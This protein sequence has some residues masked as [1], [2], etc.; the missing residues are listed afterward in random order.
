M[1]EGCIIPIKVLY[2]PL[3]HSLVAIQEGIL[4]SEHLL[5]ILVLYS[6]YNADRIY[7]PLKP[8]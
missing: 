4:L 2:S 8:C 5:A 6:R 1:N 7:Y 3:Y